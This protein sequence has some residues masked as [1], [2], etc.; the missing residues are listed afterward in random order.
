VCLLTYAREEQEMK[1]KYLM[2]NTLFAAGAA[3]VVL[4]MCT[5]VATATEPCGDFGECKVL[6]EI[7]S[8]D[9]DIGFHFL[10]D[11]DGLNSAEIQDPN[12]VTIFEDSAS[13]A[14]LEQKLTETFAESAEPVCRNKL[15]ED[16]DE[17]VVTLTEF[18][19]RWTAGTYHFFGYDDEGVLM[20]E[21][22]LTYNLPAAPTDL[23][24][25]GGV[26]SWAA[27]DDLGECATKGQLNGLV[28]SGVLPT[29][30]EDVV[31]VAWEVVFE[32][33]VEID[34]DT[35]TDEELE[36]ADALGKL[37]FTIRV[38]GDIATKEVT[39]P[40]EYLDS[41]P[42]DTPAKFEVGAIGADDNATFTEMGDICINEVG[43]G[44]D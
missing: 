4:G 10:M 11:G 3:A 43:E 42:D 5:T 40:A 39:V 17:V 41:L 7:N 22:D 1:D 38:A 14:L 37:K 32:P 28:M 13:G 31:V 9:G 33:D 36:V 12:Y 23:D 26:I 30:P 2:S 35:A 15:K 24:F 27:G 19:E 18:L 44:C 25:S 6:I 21:T 34:E 20:G 16:P 8:S 29:H